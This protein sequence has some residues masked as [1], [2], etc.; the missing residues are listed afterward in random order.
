MAGDQ[1]AGDR[2]T[3][4]KPRR[5]MVD[6]EEN[7]SVPLRSTVYGLN[8]VLNGQ[9][10]DCFAVFWAQL[11][12]QRALSSPT[13]VLKNKKC[14]KRVFLFVCSFAYFFTVPLWTS[15]EPQRT[16]FSPCTF[17]IIYLEN[18]TRDRYIKQVW[19]DKAELSYL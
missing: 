18:K 16:G 7:S 17:C 6:F 2:Q 4:R 15:K 12:R 19:R 9:L 3:H 11:C 14:C 10:M 13:F 8:N 5:I 1:Q